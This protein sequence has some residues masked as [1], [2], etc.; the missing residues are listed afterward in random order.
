MSAAAAAAAAHV[1]CKQSDVSV[2]LHQFSSSND[3]ERGQFTTTT[4]AHAHMQHQHQTCSSC[5]SDDFNLITTE[6]ILKNKQHKDEV[7]ITK[8][9][10]RQR[11]CDDAPQNLLH[12][13]INGGIAPQRT[14]DARRDT[15]HAH[16]PSS[17]PP[18]LVLSRERSKR[19]R[20]RETRDTLDAQSDKL[21]KI[22][23]NKLQTGILF[24]CLSFVQL[25]HIKAR[26]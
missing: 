14:I 5:S 15:V 18:F 26:K 2:R 12:H 21:H 6:G 11:G 25:N 4:P 13:R 8:P 20:H 16:V 23:W 9:E 24:I 3:N 1:L 17:F 19:E 7:M 10:Q 22:T